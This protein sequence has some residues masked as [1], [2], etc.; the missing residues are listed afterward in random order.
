MNYT[1][2]LRRLI[3]E[4]QCRAHCFDAELFREPAWDIL[5][6]LA[7]AGATGRSLSITA[8][9]IGSGVPATTALR[10]IGV[11]TKAGLIERQDDRND[12]RRGWLS[13]TEAGRDAMQAYLESLSTERLAA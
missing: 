9:C 13:L 5:L 8:V 11:L 4:R 6:D 10:W 7:L 3:A 12:R 1:A 2:I